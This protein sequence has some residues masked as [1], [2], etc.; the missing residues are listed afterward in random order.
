MQVGPQVNEKQAE[1][2]AYLKQSRTSV[3]SF[4]TVLFNVF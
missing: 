3:I 2:K 4:Y 1:Q